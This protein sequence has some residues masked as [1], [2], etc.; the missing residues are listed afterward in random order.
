MD[1]IPANTSGFKP[2]PEQLKFLIAEH[3][4]W[5]ATRYN[6]TL[7]G[8]QLS[9]T[10][11]DLS[12]ANLGDANL[13]RANLER[14]N[15]GDAYLGDAYLGD[16]YL[17]GANLERAYLERANL[18]RANLG[19][20]YLGDA[21]LG[22]ANLERANLSGIKTDEK[23]KIDPMCTLPEE[24]SFIAWKAVRDFEGKSIVLKLEIIG[25]HVSAYI[26]RKCRTDKARVIAAYGPLGGERT[27]KFYSKHTKSFEYEVGSVVEEKNY[28]PSPLVECTT[29]IHFFM[30]RAEALEWG[31]R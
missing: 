26:G 2:T 19:D 14:A 10:G 24:G 4:K 27:G 13:E 7:E 18:E 20:A 21:Y 17:G 28:D 3:E 29:G 9:L 11:A 15:L 6:A 16:A 31:K 22:G 23:T 30:T 25:K 12:R 1:P 8:K 5:L